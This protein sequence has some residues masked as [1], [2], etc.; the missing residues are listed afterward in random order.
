MKKRI[1]F[2]LF[3]PLLLTGPNIS[4]QR[5]TDIPGSK[6]H[7]L[8]SRFSGAVIEYYNET[9]WDVYKLPLDAKGKIDF[10]HPMLLEGKVTRIQYTVSASN[11]S[12]LVL[13]NYKAALTKSGYTIM[14]AISGGE[15]G[16]ADRPHT[17]KDKYYEAGGF[18]NGLNNAKF[19]I[20]IHFPTWKKDHSFI[21]AKGD[22]AGKDIYAKVYTVADENYTL[23]TL[24]VIEVEPPQTGMVTAED[25]SSGITRYGFIAIY[26][27]HFD[28]GKTEPN[29]DSEKAFINISAFL[30]ANPSKK[31]YIVGHTDNIGSFESNMKLSEDRAK[32]VVKELIEKHNI[33]P[34]QLSSY[35][36]SSLSPVTS[37]STPEGRTKNR[38]V[39][40]VEQ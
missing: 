16:Y 10:D 34:S 31:F 29:P 30:N 37:N 35:G 20:G 36:V 25:I 6:D 9:P 33:N 18:Y 8:I 22:Y 12:A 7:P 15:L 5:T 3:L 24:D 38:R 28:T 17:W 1:Y 26:D 23:I 4:A 13:Q 2:L 32:A 21:V 11:S 14:T 39:V 27:I 40:I 19:G